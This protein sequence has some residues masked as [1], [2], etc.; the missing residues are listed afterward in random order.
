[1][2]LFSLVKRLQILR[3]EQE[4]PKV[5]VVVPASLTKKT[6]KKKKNPQISYPKSNDGQEDCCDICVLQ[7]LVFN[8]LIFQPFVIYSFINIA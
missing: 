6:K 7:T 1:L 5:D 2:Y 4:D 3:V 8:S